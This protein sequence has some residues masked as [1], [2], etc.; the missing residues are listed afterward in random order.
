MSR[1][2]ERAYLT[3]SPGHAGPD[4]R[5]ISNR[6]FASTHSKKHL[7]QPDDV[8]R[9]LGTKN[10]VDSKMLRLRLVLSDRAEKFRARLCAPV[11]LQDSAEAR[12]ERDNRVLARELACPPPG[13]LN[14]PPRS[15]ER[16]SR[17]VQRPQR[18]SQRPPRSL[19]RPSGSDA[20]T[21]K[22]DPPTSEVARPTSDDGPTDSEDGPTDFEDGPT[23][24]RGRSSDLRCRTHRL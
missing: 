21:L 2:I 12:V 17:S 1:H 6:A 14:R 22:T 24:L 20:P 16:P 3:G 8:G 10:D 19:E 4:S 9:P 7:L 23:D 11:Q 18:R 13:S 15:L 5:D